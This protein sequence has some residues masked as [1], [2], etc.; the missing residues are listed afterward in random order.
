MKPEQIT[1]RV[2]AIVD[3]LDDV[4]T[5]VCDLIAEMQTTQREQDACSDLDLHE[6][7]SWLGRTSSRLWRRRLPDVL[8]N[9]FSESDQ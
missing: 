4:W 9:H 2:G 8:A 3:G 5:L 1:D 7:H 6:I